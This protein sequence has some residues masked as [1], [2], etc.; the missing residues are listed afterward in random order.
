[1]PK[2][3]KPA[4]ITCSSVGRAHSQGLIPYTTAI[5]RTELV[6]AEHGETLYFLIQTLMV[7]D[8][9]LMYF[10]LVTGRIDSGWAT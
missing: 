8:N 1:M 6:L 5:S 4:E 9:V 2:F 3:S 7:I 10:L